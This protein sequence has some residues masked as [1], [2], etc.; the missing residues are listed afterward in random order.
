MDRRNIWVF[1]MRLPGTPNLAWDA[2]QASLVAPKDISGLRAAI[3]PAANELWRFV[4]TSTLHGI[5]IERLRRMEFPSLPPEAH[6]RVPELSSDVRSQ[7]LGIRPTNPELMTRPIICPTCG[8]LLLTR[9]SKTLFLL[10]ATGWSK[11]FNQGRLSN[12]FRWA[13][14]RKS[15]ARWLWVCHC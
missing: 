4:V 15:R 13:I 3:F 8:Q 11:T 2:V 10:F 12:F 14:A 9:Y 7:A 6:T 5:W 1:G